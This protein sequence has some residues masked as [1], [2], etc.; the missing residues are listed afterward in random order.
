MKVRRALLSVH[1]KTGIVD[2]ARG[3]AELDVEILSTGGTGSLLRSAGVRVV[4]VAAVTGFPEILD[5]RVKTL[6]PKIS[7]GIL[8]QRD[9]PS[10]QE[11][12]AA[13]DIAPIDL[14]CSNFY[15]F[16][17]AVAR[18]GCA[19]DE[20]LE[21]IDVGGP[22]IVRA[23]AKN[24]RHVAVVTSPRRYAEVLAALR[25]GG[26]ALDEA[27]LRDLARGA[28][29]MTAQ[30]DAA[31]ANYIASQTGDVFPSFFAP[32][33]EKERDLRYGENP[34]Q[35]AALYS[36]RGSAGPSV[37]RAE[38]LWGKE[39]SFNNV[40]DLDAALR[41]LRDLAR[42]L[43]GERAAVVVVKH[44]NPVGCALAPTAADAFRRALP[45]AGE[46]AFGCVLA[47]DRV[48]DVE[49]ARAVAVP[50]N[51]VEC[52]LAPGFDP[53]ALAVLTS[54]APWGKAVRLLKVGD[55]A[56]D[57]G[58]RD[59]DVRRVLGGA[60]VQEFDTRV[61]PEGGVRVV[62]ARAPTD[63]ERADLDLAWIVAKHAASD[64]V[65]LARDGAVVGVGAGQPARVDA[66][67]LAVLRAGESAKGAVLAA[68]AFVPFAD[69]L[70]PAFAAGVTAV[71]EPGGSRHDHT[72]I[73]CADAAGAA[74]VFTG[75]RHMRH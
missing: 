59:R 53:K 74:L 64:A 68:D 67:R 52:V 29:R 37:A 16:E 17:Q 22:A 30:Y 10:H 50:E 43:S 57:L 7:G 23:A 12:L 20:A 3:L 75:M 63:A 46:G 35:R 72:L 56:A 13:H 24:H 61:V 38:V 41:L 34:F 26:G 48:V 2:F 15:P 36:Q 5:G 66:T 69:A 55:I 25:A 31:I 42:A 32:F 8:A 44:A 65:V 62:S 58:P 9:V 19:F 60:L 47:F 45:A 6:H 27:L 54:G 33:F 18:P 70:E 11:A 40:L 71:I 21:Q 51:F 39:L 1:D 14:V 4:D 73:A 28:F 49:T